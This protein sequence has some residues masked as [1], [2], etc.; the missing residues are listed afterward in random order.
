MKEH[1]Q[2]SEEQNKKPRNRPCK[3]SQLTFGKRAKAIQCS[4]SLLFPVFRPLPDV[5]TR[6]AADVSAICCDQ[7]QSYWC[8]LVR[9]RV[10]STFKEKFL[11]EWETWSQTWNLVG[12][13]PT[14]PPNMFTVK[15]LFRRRIVSSDYRW[16]WNKTTSTL[17]R[18][19]NAFVANYS[20][21]PLLKKV[22]SV[23]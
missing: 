1:T 20:T 3:C 17:L 19:T 23:C 12:H 2:S 11:K 5:C 18:E 10:C 21:S 14:P 4:R 9:G 7:V 13:A 22:P 15:N 6:Y 8:L 16:V